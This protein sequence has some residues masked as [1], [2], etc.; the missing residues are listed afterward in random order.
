[1]H[2]A[3]AS[4]TMASGAGSN[5][6]RLRAFKRW[7]KWQSVEYSDALELTDSLDDGV[8]VRA[9]RD[10]KEGDVVATIPKS[11]CLTVRTSG[12]SEMIEAA[13]LDGCLGLSVALMFERSLGGE[14]PWAGYLQLLPPQEPLPLTWTLSD[15]D[16]L[17]RGTELHRTVKEDRAL[18]YEDWKE[19]ILPL[20]DSSLPGSSELNPD[21]FGVD[22]YLSARSL[23]A[24]R[25]FA[26]DEYHGSGM[27]PLADL[28]NHKTGAEDVHFT[29]VS[30]YSES[31]DSD[32]D[33][34]QS[35]DS[36]GEEDST[37]SPTQ[38]IAENM[39]NGHSEDGIPA[40]EVDPTVLQM[41]MVKNVKAGIEVFNTYGSVGNAALLHRYGF[42]EENNPYDIVN[43]DLELVLQWSSSSF[44]SRHTRARIALWRRLGY[45]ACES[46]GTEYYEISFGGEPQLELLILL[47]IILMPEDEYHPLDLAVSKGNGSISKVNHQNSTCIEQMARAMSEDLVL[48]EGVSNALL[49]LADMRESLYGNAI[50]DDMEALSRCC[51]IQDRKMYHSLMLRISERRIL[52]KLRCYASARVASLKT[53]KAPQRKRLKRK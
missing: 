14:S 11:A 50:Q 22:Q 52:G 49:T 37:N 47:Y 24:S 40:S 28:F 23:I 2:A 53:T 41:I 36:L 38:N 51:H 7:M 48:T 43:I 26:I 15:V 20:L 27:V 39:F 30:S 9:V 44:S 21:F 19:C 4:K 1:M 6:R 5:S 46:Q 35:T 17:L 31:D 18:I 45:S 8:T 32:V 3:T 42:T 16:L 25:S 12:A 29:N 33:D 13:G 34:N 10:L